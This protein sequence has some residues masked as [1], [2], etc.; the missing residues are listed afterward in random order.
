[1]LSLMLTSFVAL[2]AIAAPQKEA[3]YVCSER[4]G[5]ET[6]IVLRL[7]RDAPTAETLKTMEVRS[8]DDTLRGEFVRAG[9]GAGLTSRDQNVTLWKQGDEST[10]AVLNLPRR[11]GNRFR[12][13]LIV[14]SAGVAPADLLQ[15]RCKRAN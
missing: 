12:A 13:E 10:V 5:L 11:L 15:I 7:D 6:P 1:M 9:M 4:D 14:T 3:I 8:V 2:S